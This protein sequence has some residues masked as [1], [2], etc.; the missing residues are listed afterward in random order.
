M[1]AIRSY[2][3]EEGFRESDCNMPEEERDQD[4][5]PVTAHAHTDV[6]WQAFKGVSCESRHEECLRQKQ[7]AKKMQDATNH[8]NVAN[9]G[10]FQGKAAFFDQVHSNVSGESSESKADEAPMTASM[11]F[12]RACM[13]GPSGVNR[14][15]SY[16]VCYTKL[17]RIQHVHHLQEKRM[18]QHSYTE[19]QDWP[20]HCQGV[21]SE[22]SYK[23]HAHPQY[24]T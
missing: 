18:R 15:T 2:Y 4:T 23:H 21:L 14:I 8:V 7:T 17:L 11:A 9:E 24:G 22:A 3:G 12:M 20:S 13:A 19:P 6:D 16:N 5:L 1:Y 10:K